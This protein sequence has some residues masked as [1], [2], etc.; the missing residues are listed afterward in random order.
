MVYILSV[1]ASVDIVSPIL[2]RKTWKLLLGPVAEPADS[3]PNLRVSRLK[4]TA[5]LGLLHAYDHAGRQQSIA[6][7]NVWAEYGK[8]IKSPYLGKYFRRAFGFLQCTV[9]LYVFR[10]FYLHICTWVGIYVVITVKRYRVK[11][12]KAHRAESRR[13]QARVSDLPP[14]LELDGQHLVLL[15]SMSDNTYR[16]LSNR[17]V[18]L[19]VGGQSVCWVSVV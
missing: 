3:N 17:D 2:Q 11:S 10:D 6:M 8:D 15:A 18:H 5:E 4:L 9:H 16:V 1:F 13:D 7:I 14:L 12:V 19:R